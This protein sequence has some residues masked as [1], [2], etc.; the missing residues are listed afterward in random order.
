MAIRVELVSARDRNPRVQTSVARKSLG[1]GIPTGERRA[2][3]TPLRRTLLLRVV[4]GVALLATLAY[5]FT[6]S[7]SEDVRAAPLLPD[8]GAGMVVLDLSLSIGQFDRIAETLRRLAREDERTGLVV[9]SDTSYEL[10]PPGSPGRELESLVRFFTP[11]HPDRDDY[12]L[13]PWEAGGFRAGTRISGGLE[14]ARE[15]LQRSG[16]EN[17]SI[18]LVSD[19]DVAQDGSNLSSVLVA[20]KRDGIDLRLVPLASQPQNRAFFEQL[21]GR[22]AFVAEADSDAPLATSEERR[23]G[24]ALPWRYLIV[25]S[26]LVLLLSVNERLLARLEVA[27]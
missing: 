18:L 16:V 19:L 17:G 25:A 10:L 23:F 22:A 9:F 12:P 27:R 7:R 13:N 20:L 11:R 6:L 21:A 4:L 14:T 8:G 2:W 3:Q 1:R 5:A 26:L 15:A 24:G